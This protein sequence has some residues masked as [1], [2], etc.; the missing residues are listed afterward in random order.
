MHG[1]EALLRWHV[2]GRYLPPTQ[3]IPVLEATGMIEDLGY[4]IFERAARDS[5]SWKQAGLSGVRVA[6]NVSPIQFRTANFLPAVANQVDAEQHQ[7]NCQ[8]RQPGVDE[9]VQCARLTVGHG[10][11]ARGEATGDKQRRGDEQD[12]HQQL[13]ASEPRVASIS[14]WATST[15]LPV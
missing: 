12:A 11:R 13:D 15:R 2:D 7:R 5:L 9:P 14:G 1:V 8:R 4:W 3:F 10:Q 6:I